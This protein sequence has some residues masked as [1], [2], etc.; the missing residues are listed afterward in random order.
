MDNRAY[1]KSVVCKYWLGDLSLKEYCEANKLPYDTVHC[2]FKVFERERLEREGQKGNPLLSVIEVNNSEE[3][4][5]KDVHL[6]QARYVMEINSIKLGFPL[7]YDES[8]ARLLI[9]VAR[10]PERFLDFFQKIITNK[11][12]GMSNV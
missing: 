8:I 10:Y 4:W 2:W 12:K 1:W 9:T 3:N 7:Q 6:E 11:S 5:R